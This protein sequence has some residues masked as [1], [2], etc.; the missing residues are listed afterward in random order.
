MKLA[1]YWT[2]QPG[3]AEDENGNPVRVVSRGWSNDSLEAANALARDIA[4]RVAARVAADDWSKKQYEYGERP[5]PEPVLREFHASD[6]ALSAVVT[7]NAYGALVLNTRDLMFVDID[8]EEEATGGEAAAK[9][10][11]SGFKSLFGGSKP[12]TATPVPAPMDPA[13]AEIQRVA[14]GHSLPVRVYKTAAGYRVLVLSPSFEPASGRSDLLLK[15]FGSDKLYIRLCRMQE[16]FRARLTPKPW[17]CGMQQPPVTFPFADSKDEARF[18]EWEAKYQAASA[19]YATCQF[20]ASFGGGKMEPGF[21]E[22]V[23][24][25]DQETKAKSGLG[26]A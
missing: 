13:L 7:R 4:R 26:L 5:L 9:K 14:Q 23:E 20:V 6:D 17:R 22:L 3:E 18:R 25:H 8:R 15:E 10:L 12:E 16:S 19:R 24:H 1:R 2:R 11:M 21:Q